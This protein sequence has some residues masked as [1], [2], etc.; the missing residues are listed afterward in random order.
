MAIWT[1]YCWPYVMGWF[2]NGPGVAPEICLLMQPGMPSLNKT[3][4]WRLLPERQ[5]PHLPN[6]LLKVRCEH[7]FIVINKIFRQRQI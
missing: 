2:V 6:E 3:T 1:T 7:L 5:F 4:N